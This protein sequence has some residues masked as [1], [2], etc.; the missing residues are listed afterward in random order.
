MS[1]DGTERNGQP[2]PHNDEDQRIRAAQAGDRSAFSLLVEG[3][4]P[5]L[6]RWLYQLTRDRHLAEDLAQDA[7]MKAF[8]HLPRFRAGS[9]FRAWLFRIAHNAF[10][11]HERAARR[12]RAALPEELP[13]PEQG[14]LDQVI[15]KE[16]LARVGSALNQ[17][18]QDLRA[19]LLLRVEEDL[20]FREIAAILDLTE[21]TARWRVFKA[22]QKL[23][24]KLEVR[25][26]ERERT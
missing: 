16:T 25:S 14:P 3:Y 20:S 5:R 1:T 19:A 11:N 21:E 22:R 4:W 13:D 15:S 2:E 23:L 6:F 26:E 12:Q 10:S 24:A 9:N 7:F 18:P 17:L 8:A